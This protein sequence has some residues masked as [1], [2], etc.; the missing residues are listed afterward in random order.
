M[1]FTNKYTGSSITLGRCVEPKLLDVNS[2]KPE[3]I[4]RFRGLLKYSSISDRQNN[5]YNLLID[6][7][8]YNDKNNKKMKIFL[9][10][11]DEKRNTNSKDVLPWCWV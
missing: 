5:W 4:D 7:Y 10:K 2:L 6:G 11:L 9:A 1:N 8:R 3:V